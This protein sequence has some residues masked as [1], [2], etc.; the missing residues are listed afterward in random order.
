MKWYVAGKKQQQ[1]FGLNI[2]LSKTLLKQILPEWWIERERE[3][4]K[5]KKFA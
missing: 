3:K 2:L 5:N 1:Q 4:N